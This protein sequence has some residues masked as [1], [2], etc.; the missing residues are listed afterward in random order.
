M[1][2]KKPPVFF[3]VD[4]DQFNIFLNVL[5]VNELT[6]IDGICDWSKKLQDKLLRY[7]VPN[8]EKDT[9]LEYI[10][11]GFYAQE[12]AEMLMQFLVFNSNEVSDKDY[13]SVLLGFREK[14]L[15]SRN[16]NVQN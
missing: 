14:Y 7:S 5:K 1:L 3:K 9:N 13:Y 15:N 16:T 2:K 10:N 11:I 12:A 4:K 8:K 6:N